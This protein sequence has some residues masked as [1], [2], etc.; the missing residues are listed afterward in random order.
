MVLHLKAIFSKVISFPRS[1]LLAETRFYDISFHT[2]VQLIDYFTS[3]NICRFSSELIDYMV[4]HS[5][6]PKPDPRELK[7]LT[8]SNSDLYDHQYRRL[9]MY[10]QGDPDIIDALHDDDFWTCGYR[11]VSWVLWRHH[12]DKDVR[13]YFSAVALDP[14]KEIYYDPTNVSKGSDIRNQIIF[15][16]SLQKEIH[17]KVH[18]INAII[19]VHRKSIEHP[20]FSSFVQKNISD[21]FITAE[22]EEIK[23]KINKFERI[24][25]KIQ[26][27]ESDYHTKEKNIHEWMLTPD[28][29]LDSLFENFENFVI[30][31]QLVIPP[32]IHP[33]KYLKS[34]S[35]IRKQSDNIPL[36]PIGKPNIGSK[37]DI[38][39]SKESV[40]LMYFNDIYQAKTLSFVSSEI[41]SDVDILR[42]AG[43]YYYYTDQF[44]LRDNS[45]RFFLPFRMTRL[46][47]SLNSKTTLGTSIEEKTYFDEIIT[48]KEGFN[49]YILN[50]SNAEKDQINNNIEEHIFIGYR[51]NENYFVTFEPEELEMGITSDGLTYAYFESPSIRQ[52]KDGRRYF[53]FSEAYELMSLLQLYLPKLSLCSKLEKICNL[54]TSPEEICSQL[55][56]HDGSIIRNYLLMIF[57]FGLI[58]R[59]AYPILRRQMEE[60]EYEIS[61][62]FHSKHETRS[63]SESVVTPIISNIID[64]S[65]NMN[66]TCINII[67]MFRITDESSSLRDSYVY[68]VLINVS[69]GTQCYRESSKPLCVSVVRYL[70]ILFG[71]NIKNFELGKF[72]SIS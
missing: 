3:K 10:Y 32:N 19:D 71:V 23:H 24:L 6:L 64:L 30:S 35:Y 13:A 12:Y 33:I 63:I 21:F 22:I 57:E 66:I 55:S 43:G 41:L 14:H 49:R 54:P 44:T 1:V 29:I 27:F 4:L 16:C 48:A 56:E 9:F 20:L 34:D 42:S 62:I 38:D 36:P 58:C 60:H 7:Y 2:T 45:F 17:P 11:Y 28:D 8:H 72:D 50:Q 59:G 69:E 68:R 5:L 37:D 52:A 51:I 15:A 46:N 31:R 26:K 67:K 61:P 53:S 39:D 47:Y 25:E 70:K 18:A 65:D 40:A